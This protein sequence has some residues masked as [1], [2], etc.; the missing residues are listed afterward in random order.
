M[1][2]ASEERHDLAATHLRLVMVEMALRSYKCDQGSGP[3]NLGLLVPKY[4]NRLPT[5]PFSGNP[6]VYHPMG[7]NW[8]LY[9]LGPD[10][11]DDGGKPAGEIMSGDY[12]F[13]FGVT[14]SD[15]DQKKGDLLYDSG[16]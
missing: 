4:L 14:K 8:I 11:V 12:G 3:E 2:K 9:S 13:I 7:T 5:D 1:R 16:W 6:L 15:K 10:R